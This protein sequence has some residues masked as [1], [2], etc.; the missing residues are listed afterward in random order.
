MILSSGQVNRQESFDIFNNS[1]LYA[2]LK[3][4]VKTHPSNEKKT[5]RK[6]N[7]NHNYSYNNVDKNRCEVT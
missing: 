3:T 2:F 4:H 7:I 1:V 6:M 5:R